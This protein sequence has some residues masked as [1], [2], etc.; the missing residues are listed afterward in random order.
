MTA[1]LHI[2]ITA[3]D[4]LYQQSLELNSICEYFTTTTELQ[5]EQPL[6]QEGNKEKRKTCGMLKLLR[7]HRKD[8]ATHGCSGLIGERGRQ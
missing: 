4:L 5:P 6:E 8:E 2:P 1:S 3:I 7:Y